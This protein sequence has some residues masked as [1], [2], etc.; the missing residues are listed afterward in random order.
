MSVLP[1]LIQYLAVRI[2]YT[3]CSPELL[4][5]RVRVRVYI[6][7]SAL[8]LSYQHYAVAVI[9]TLEYRTVLFLFAS[10]LSGRASMK[11]RLLWPQD[12]K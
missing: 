2:F 12:G 7:R 8:C 6:M 10:R 5:S 3:S 1:V 11:G 9:P 4:S